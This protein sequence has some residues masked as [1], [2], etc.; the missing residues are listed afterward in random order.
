[1]RSRMLAFAGALVLLAAPA[2]AQATLPAPTDPR[3]QNAASLSGKAFGNVDFG[4]HFTDITGDEAR[5]QRYRDLRDGP[6]ADN[7]LFS[8]RGND[9]ALRATGTKIGYRDQRFT[10]EYRLVGKVKA[11]FDW[12]QIPLFISD[13]TRSF[14]TE[15]EPGVFRLPDTMQTSN[16]AGATTIRDFSS[17]AVPVELRNR[18]HLGTFDFVY[19]ASRDLDLKVNVNTSERKGTMQYGAPFGFSNLIELPTPLDHRTTDTRAVLEWAN[20]QGMIS[21]GWDGSWF[22]NAVE[23]LIWD[24][25]IKITDAPSYSSAY[26]D[27]KSSAQGRMALWPDN[28]LQYVH[29]TASYV[30]PWRGRV[31]GYLALGDS[32][33]NQ[34]LLPHTINAAIPVVPLERPTAETEIR[35]TIFNLQYSVRPIRPFSLVARYRYVDLDNRTPHF[36][37]FGRVRFDG[38]LDDAASSPEPE[39]YSIRRKNFD[40]DGTF[41]VIPYT[42]LRVGYSNWITDRT[43]RV[44][45]QNEENV[46]RVSLDTMG[47][48]WMT[49]RALYE[50]SRRNAL[51][52]H[53]AL[54]EEFG[55][56]PGMRHYDVADRDR[57]RG[58]LIFTVNPLP[59]LSFTASAGV[60]REE[61]PDSE[62]GLQSYDSDQYAVGFDLIPSDRFALNAVYAWENY[63]SV[64]ESRTA[65]PLPDPTFL[66]PRRNWFLDYG[67]KVKNVDVGFDVLDLAPKTD[68]RFG[69]NWSD[70][71]DTYTYVLPPN[72]VIATPRQLPPVLNELFRGNVDLSYRLTPRVRLGGVY[73]YEDYKTQDFA[74]GSQIISDIA[75]PTIQPGATPVAPTTVLLGYMY[76]PYT[77]HAGMVRLTYLW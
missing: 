52:T 31:T 20:Q 43:L 71:T 69:I 9:W 8:R 42:A 36:E 23:T 35:N 33:Q 40:V 55:E 45:E 64:T 38:V 54:L 14:Y 72:T 58:T 32:K 53:E 25:P 19:T 76:R 15:V 37:T 26:S 59:S 63:A 49:V 56:Q 30:T 75:L 70:V 60:G 2:F 57:K 12:N 73:W 22:N 34:P 4:V 47:N 44:I 13:D 6:L 27:G 24:N 48:R 51:H 5:A 41:N 10:G 61:Y 77:A 1:M 50:D 74:L 46:Y 17:T 65:N 16:Q 62:F 11:S 18:R 39:F 7:L 29:G 3:E 66:D 28:T 68:L 67:G 21:V